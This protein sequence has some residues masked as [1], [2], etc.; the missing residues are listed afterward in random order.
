MKYR[1]KYCGEL[2][3]NDQNTKQTL[4]GWIDRIREVGGGLSFILLRDRS[5][6]IQ[7]VVDASKHPALH[8]ASTKLHHEDVICIEGLVSPRAEKDINPQMKTGQIEIIV[9]KI[10]IL[11][12]ANQ[13]P[14]NVLN[15]QNVDE[16]L[17]MK[18][19]FIDLRNLEVM[20]SFK[21]RHEI[22]QSTR[23]FFTEQGFWE[24]DTPYLAKSTPEGARDFLVP[25]RIHSGHFYALTQSPQIFKQLLM[26]GGIDKY[27]QI[28]RCF[29]DE[30]FRLD[31]QP[32]FSQIDFECA[33]T[34]NDEL[35]RLIE[36]LVKT[37]FLQVLG[38]ELKTPFQEITYQ[39][40]MD[41]YGSDKPDLRNPLV[42]KNITPYFNKESY[43]P[44]FERIQL[45]DSFLAIRLPGDKVSL[46]RK[47]SDDF[48]ET[49]KSE[50]INVYFFKH[51]EN[52]L[53]I[54]LLQEADRTELE[55]FLSS[56]VQD[57]IVALLG[58]KNKI[59]SLMGKIRQ[60][61]G[62]TCHL[63]DSSEKYRFAWITD[64]PLF[65]WNEEDQ[66]YQSAHHLFTLPHME[67]YHRWIKTEPEKIRSASFDLVLN[68]FEL[69]SGGLRIYQADLQHEILRFM[70]LPESLIQE[71]FGFLMEAMSYG[72]PPEGGFAIGLDRLVMLL[73]NKTSLREVIAFPKNTRGAS[74]LTGEPSMVSSQQLNDLHLILSKESDNESK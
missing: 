19:R 15:S 38:K 29:R 68:G 20:N 47:Q 21:M 61:L 55:H 4:S 8:E 50:G 49:Y 52:G 66:R 41:S 70:G 53:S 64:F 36:E 40:A 54:N 45:G 57:T 35:K 59:T 60:E 27:F 32:E 44:F 33:F 72:A 6:V 67:D 65:E 58:P 2:S 63:I 73:A 71:Q 18:Y 9:D 12:S 43:S 25:S 48:I 46:S 69:G 17:R 39:D 11:S 62:Q 51:K 14:F 42:I 56:K 7:L 28:C 31:R 37:I 23:K 22:M 30:D 1:S 16:N 26:M 74:P 3:I 34:T 13:L 24:V 5:G 10:E